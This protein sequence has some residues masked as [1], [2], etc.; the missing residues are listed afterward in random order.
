MRRDHRLHVGSR[1][2][3][4][5]DD[6]SFSFSPGFSL[7]LLVRRIGVT[8]LTVSHRSVR[9]TSKPLKRFQELKRPIPRLR[10]G[11]NEKSTI[12]RPVVFSAR[13][14]GRKTDRFMLRFHGLLRRRRNFLGAHALS[15]YRLHVLRRI[16]D[17]STPASGAQSLLC[18]ASQN[19]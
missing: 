3:F 13:V 2:K 17:L 15:L 5:L 16:R 11:E 14:S 10:P 6:A 8:V 4:S 18:K 9:L 7:R 12:C 19:R 1:V